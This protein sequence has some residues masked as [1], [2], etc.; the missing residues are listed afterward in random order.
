MAWT[1]AALAVVLPPAAL[2]VPGGIGP[3]DPATS[4]AEGIS[5]LYWIVF[6]VTAGVFV[7]VEAALLIFVFR[8]RRRRRPYEAEGPQIHG[9]TRLE[10]VWTLI[11][12]LILVGITVATILKIPSVQAQGS[13][14]EDAL[15]VRVEAHQFYWQYVYPNGVITL[16][17]LRL[18]VGREVELELTSLDVI[19][20]W[21]VPELAGKLDAVPGRT[22]VLA[23]EPKRTGVFRGACAEFCGILHTRQTI[24][25][26]VVSQGEF[27]RWLGRQQQAQQAGRSGLGRQTWEA[28]CAK[29]HGLAGEGGVG[30]PIAGSPSLATRE[31]LLPLLL[32]GQETPQFRS[33]MPAV[34]KGWPDRQVAAL[35]DYLREN[36]AR[37]GGG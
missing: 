32:E 35:L 37:E 36:V 27:D 33:Y 5:D 2:A 14:D 20:S 19:H 12:A 34:G 3:R 16:D 9:N 8:F 6:A 26:E 28:V 22:N 24:R 11:P 4:S 15:T 23:F 1:I 17:T 21:W 18:P 10:I 13:H 31:G 30:P 25:V 7:L 29:C